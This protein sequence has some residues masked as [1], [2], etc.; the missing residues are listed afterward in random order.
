MTATQTD[1]PKSKQKHI[2]W[3]TLFSLLDTSSGASMSVREMLIQLHKAGYKITIL[4]ATIF[5]SPRGLTRLNNH[6]AQ[7]Q[8]NKGVF[9]NIQDGPL[10][11]QTLVTESIS[12]N[13]VTQ[14]EE[15][16]WFHEFKRIVETEKPDILFFYG[17][18]P[19]DGYIVKTAK[20][21]GCKTLAYLANPNY[22]GKQWCQDVDRIVTDSYATAGFYKDREGIDL[23]PVGKFI[24][25][26]NFVAEQHALKNVLFINPSFSKGAL[27]VVQLALILEEKRPDIQFEVVES[28]GQIKQAIELLTA[29]QGNQRS[30]LSNILITP[31]QKKMKMVYQ[32]ARCVLAPSLWWESSGRITV[33]AMLNGLPVIGTNRGGI[34]EMVGDAGLLINLAEAFYQEPYTRTPAA[35]SLIPVTDFIERLYDDEAL[36]QSFREKAFA[37]AKQL[38]MQYSTQRLI[39][40][41]EA[42]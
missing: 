38:D 36:Y 3:A 25:P 13:Q 12:R 11:H 35:K 30:E 41:I 14:P 37:Q 29:L 20:N 27:I 17:G 34:P 28:R 15:G 9:Y 42:L 19:F 18:Y 8:Q 2:L 21:L 6:W 16:V 4:G 40:N 7:M 24:E 31:N 1:R 39:E 32:R 5:D 33:E 26:S 23:F 10:T 22:H